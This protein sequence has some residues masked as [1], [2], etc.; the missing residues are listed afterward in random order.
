MIYHV[1]ERLKIDPNL[2][3]QDT[4]RYLRAECDIRNR[5]VV[6]CI[7]GEKIE[8]DL[9]SFFYIVDGIRKEYNDMVLK[10]YVDPRIIEQM[11][12]EL[13]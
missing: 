12:K 10:S 1:I 13:K 3:W 5:N 9:D 4:P 2:R 7:G 11:E 8:I 6:L